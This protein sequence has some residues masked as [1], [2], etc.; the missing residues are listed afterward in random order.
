MSLGFHSIPTGVRRYAHTR[1]PTLRRNKRVSVMNIKTKPVEAQTPT[2]HR[3]T[4]VTQGESSKK[5]GTA[6]AL[7]LQSTSNKTITQL[8]EKI[9]AIQDTQKN[10]CDMV[11]AHDSQQ[12]SFRDQIANLVGM[13]NKLDGNSILENFHALSESTELYISQ[14]E[15]K[16]NE[17]E[18]RIQKNANAGNNKVQLATME[19]KVNEHNKLF[20]KCKIN[21]QQLQTATRQLQL[22]NYKMIWAFGTAERELHVYS[23]PSARTEYEIPD[24]AISPFE[25]VLI[26]YPMIK[27]PDCT[28]VKCRRLYDSGDQVECWVILRQSNVDNFSSFTFSSG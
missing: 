7:Q 9:G 1:K 2:G 18:S 25:R 5:K 15:S 20:E 13:Y 22:E 12:Q 8:V 23:K 26:V 19:K 27:Q 6:S 21:M 17:L 24:V 10:V 4:P 11:N 28:W 3:N 16:I 14:L